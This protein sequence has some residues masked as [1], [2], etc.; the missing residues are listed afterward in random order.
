M[1]QSDRSDVD[2]FA[3]IQALVK[4]EFI[5]SYWHHLL[6]YSDACL[7]EKSLEKILMNAK[8]EWYCNMT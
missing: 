4:H 1:Q 3:S 7:E 6:S 8:T 5:V 2:N